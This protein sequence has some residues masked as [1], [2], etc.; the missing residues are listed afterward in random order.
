MSSE[1]SNVDD[2][3]K[4]FLIVHQIPWLSDTINAFKYHLDAKP[5]IL[6]SPQR[7]VLKGVPHQGH[8]QLRVATLI[9]FSTSE[10]VLVDKTLK[11]F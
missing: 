2:K 3:G 5:L 11:G 1:E 10:F 9:G 6:K 8:H 4:E 7:I